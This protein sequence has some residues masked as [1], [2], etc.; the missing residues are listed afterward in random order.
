MH[1]AQLTTISSPS[2]VFTSWNTLLPT[3]VS[4]ILL[5]SLFVA[6]FIFFIR[7]LA[8][9]FTLM[10]SGGEP[11]KIKSATTSLTHALLGLVIVVS[12]YFIAQIIQVVFGLRIL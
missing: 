4:R 7:L 3:L 6:G 1:L 8:A 12:A 2:T 11:A 9:G 10:T 5:F